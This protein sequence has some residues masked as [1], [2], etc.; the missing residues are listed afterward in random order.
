M[1]FVVSGGPFMTDPTIGILAGM[2]PRS[3][4]P[5]VDQVV[6]ECQQ[7]YGARYDDEFPAMM[8]Y[9]LPTPFYIDRPI[10]HARLEATISAG[11]R[12]LEATGVEFIAMPCNAAH[13]YYRKLAQMIDIPLLN[14]IDETLKHIPSH[15]RHS[16][17]LATRPT[18]ESGMYQQAM[19]KVGIQ[20]IEHNTWQGQI[21]RLIHMVKTNS[22]PANART[23]WQHILH[24]MASAGVDT[25]IIACTDL[26]VLRTPNAPFSILD[27]TDCLARVTVQRWLANQNRLARQG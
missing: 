17:L 20:I 18:A 10:D 22:N 24:E 2:G 6:T 4:A 7:Q 25:A 26:S 27:A 3:T 23:L 21:D 16:A 14:M 9:S 8:I 13:R 11:L 1:Q 5:F 12:K 15:T 19:H